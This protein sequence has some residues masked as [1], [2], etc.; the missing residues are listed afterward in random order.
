MPAE[1]D[2][3]FCIE[4]NMP[5]GSHDVLGLVYRPCPQCLE[6]CPGCDG[7]GLFPTDFTCL[8]CFRQH[9]AA[10]GLIPVLCALCSGVVDL[11]PTPH[12]RTEVTGHDHH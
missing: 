9:M 12:R 10:I 5:A 11:Y 1:D 4:S 8:A 3:L 7:D 2:C 6:T